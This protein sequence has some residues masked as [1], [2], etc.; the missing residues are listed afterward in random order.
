M[1]KF[2][3]PYNSQTFDLVSSSYGD[4]YDVGEEK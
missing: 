4:M 3:S 1:Q 2:L